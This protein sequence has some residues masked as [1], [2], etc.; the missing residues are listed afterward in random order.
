M[1]ESLENDLC[2]RLCEVLDPLKID[3][4]VPDT[5]D[6]RHVLSSLEIFIT[7]AV[8]E[9]HDD[10]AWESLDGILPV[11]STKKGPR[12]VEL[13]GGAY[14]VSDQSV[15]PIHVRLQ[16]SAAAWE[17]GWMECYLGK[18]SRGRLVREEFYRVMSRMQ[19]YSG[20]VSSIDWF[21]KIGFGEKV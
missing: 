15:L 7:H 1:N 4:P 9:I 12:E 17:V 14:L 2:Q 20:E 18:R 16:V 13:W 10:F 11:E 21:Y 5:D 19:S 3:D 8:R 6:Y